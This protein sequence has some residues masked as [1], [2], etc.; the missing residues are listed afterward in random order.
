MAATRTGS[1]IIYT[2]TMFWRR[3]RQDQPGFLVFGLGN[4]GLDYVRTRHNVGWWVLDELARRRGV[5]RRASRHRGQVEYCAIAGVQTAL[6]KPTTFMN[7][8]GNCISPWIHEH[9]E[10][11]WLVVLDDISMEPGKLRLRRQGSSGGH[12]G[13][14]S[15]IDI[16]DTDEFMR[17]KI[18][19][20]HA[21]PD[22]DTAEWVLTPPSSS[23]ETQIAAGIQRAAD[24]IVLIAQGQW[25]DALHLMGTAGKD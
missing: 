17:L 5:D 3:R 18:G 22:V 14:Q 6:V 12:K 8:S 10:A 21:P 4:P 23:E 16:L 1:G 20:G 9:A 7:R 13:V 25:D 19:V 11:N 15:I 24:A 2:A